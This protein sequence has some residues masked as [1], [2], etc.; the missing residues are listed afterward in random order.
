MKKTLALVF[1]MMVA[2]AAFAQNDV[3]KFLGIPIDGTK[4]GMIQQLKAKGYTYNPKLDCLEGEFNGRDVN[5]YI[6]TNNNKVWRI[7]VV[8]AYP[9]RNESDIRIR[10]NT[11]CQQFSRNEKYVQADKESNYLID[12]NED[13]SYQM[14]V[15]NKRY[16]ASYWQ[17]SEKYVDTTGLQNWVL[18]EIS[19]E[20]T[21]SEI[22]DM[23]EEQRKQIV[24]VLML[25]YAIE[26]RSK[27]S[28]W[29]MISEQYGQYS[30][31]MFYDNEYNHSNGEDL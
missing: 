7:A 8:D 22:E 13:I 16:E 25:K 14:S 4:S 19:K 15:N 29:F 26:I 30:I 31:A 23:S 6:A 9:T 2:I 10:F 24:M 17:I 12:E 1:T 3:T 18:E 21:Q 5:L 20:Y 27:K 28:V 11:L